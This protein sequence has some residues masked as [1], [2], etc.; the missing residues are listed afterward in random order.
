[1]RYIGL[2]VHKRVIEVCILDEDGKRIVRQ[3]LPCERTVL[4]SFGKARLKKDDHLALEATTNTWAVVELLEPF[5]SAITVGNPMKIRAIAEAKVKTDKIDAEVLAQLLRCGYLP[6]VWHPDARTRQ[7]RKLTTGCASLSADATRCKN[8]IQ[9]IFAEL[10]IT[11]PD[12]SLFSQA[13]RKW[14]DHVPL[15]PDD[16]LLLEGQLRLLS[17]IEMQI[18]LLDTKLAKLAHEQ[19]QVRLLMTLPGVGFA[20]AQALLAALGDV[21]RFRDGDHA[22]SYLGLAPSTYQSAQ[23]CYHGSITKRGRSHARWMMTQAAQHLATQPGPLGVFFRRIRQRKSQNVAV[24]AG[25][26][27]L[28]TIAFLMLKNDESYRYGL[29]DATQRKLFRLDYL[30]TG[31]RRRPTRVPGL[32]RGLREPGTKACTS[33]SLPQVYQMTHV[34]PCIAPDNLP[35]GEKA[36]LE[37]E[38]L[39]AFVSSIQ[40]PQQQIKPLNKRL[41]KKRTPPA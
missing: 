41:P 4:L 7:L 24:V 36:V 33:R 1:M 38:Q 37:A 22:A 34:P 35:E 14:L 10:L 8:R 28:V 2:D 12:V 3:S 32:K 18:Q 25:A 20:A 6:A 26:R 9:S 13:G 21:S 11:L 40:Q 39:T 5:V 31:Q 30:A 15:P 17:T 27:K 19:D 23:R 29:P 16:R